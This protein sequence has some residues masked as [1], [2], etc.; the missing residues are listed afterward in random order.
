[1]GII[2]ETGWKD[3]EVMFLNLEDV[4]VFDFDVYDSIQGC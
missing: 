4:S 1:M 3:E 2:R